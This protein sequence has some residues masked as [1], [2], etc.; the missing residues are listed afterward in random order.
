MLLFGVLA[1]LLASAASGKDDSA[2]AG[3]A[4]VVQWVEA[5]GAQHQE[6]VAA[7]LKLLKAKTL[8]KLLHVAGGSVFESR[9]AERKTTL[10]GAKGTAKGLAK[11][12]A[13]GKSK[14]KGSASTAE[15]VLRVRPL[16]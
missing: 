9:A 5:F 12:K 10:L 11:A 1:P 6:D 13:K 4:A 8:G 16:A 15:D 2:P 7:A 14:G 3:P